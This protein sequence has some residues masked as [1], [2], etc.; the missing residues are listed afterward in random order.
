MQD[1]KLFYSVHYHQLTPIKQEEL[2]REIIVNYPQF[3]FDRLATF[4]RFGK[5]TNTAIYICQGREFVFV[6]GD[7]VVLGWTDF[8]E[9]M[10]RDTQQEMVECLAEYDV[11]DIDGFLKSSMSPVRE[12]TIGPMLVERKL[13]E[14]GWY[15]VAHDSKILAP[16][17]KHIEE[18]R[19][20]NY[21]SLTVH[22]RISIRRVEGEM[23]SYAYQSLT[24]DKLIQQTQREGFDLPNED[25]WE[26]LCGGGSR[27]LFRWG[28][29]FDYTMKLKHF[30]GGQ[31][32]DKPY[33]LEEP[34]HFGLSMAYDPYKY[35]V[36]N[37]DACFLKGGDGGSY[38]CGGMGLVIG[39]LPVATYF[40]P[41]SGIEDQ[42]DY[43][44]DI[45]GDYTLYRRIFSLK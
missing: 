7:T 25:Q 14:I 4:E 9:G 23:L 34:N 1:K 31:L 18:F 5:Q 26:Y 22:K 37:D 35:E 19:S 30:T 8:V 20:Q 2:L 44:S 41:Q 32:D 29:S 21:G 10:D 39:Y 45:G 42:L 13:N 3:S 43:K 16:Y 24:Y 28:D 27:T 12:V 15:Q 11:E 6:P 17:Q 36:V 38:I 40:R 33:T